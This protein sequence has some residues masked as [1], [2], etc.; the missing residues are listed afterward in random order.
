MLE[1]RSD[2]EL[3]AGEWSFKKMIGT[4]DKT[5]GAGGWDEEEHIKEIVKIV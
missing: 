1:W 5:W 4:Q 2:E 3:E